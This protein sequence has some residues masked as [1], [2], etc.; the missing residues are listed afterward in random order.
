MVGSIANKGFSYDDDDD[1]SDVGRTHEKE[2]H[3][4]AQ[5]SSNAA[6]MFTTSW[7]LKWTRYQ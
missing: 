2:M 7:F 4:H 5:M 6:K 3:S 1:I